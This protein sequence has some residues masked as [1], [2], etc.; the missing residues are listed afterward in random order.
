M[1]NTGE[2]KHPH[3]TAGPSE[4]E[5]M[6]VGRRINDLSPWKSSDLMEIYFT[7]FKGGLIRVVNFAAPG[8]P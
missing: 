4:A 5:E 1:G 7:S 3:I 2:A 8:A 6:R